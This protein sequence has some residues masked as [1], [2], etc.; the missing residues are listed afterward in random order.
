MSHELHTFISAL[1]PQS[2][3]V[4]LTEVTV[5]QAYVLLHLTA[6]A[7]TA[8]CPRCA[9]PSSSVHSRYQRQLADLPWGSLAVRIRLTVRKF[10]CRH[11]SCPRRIFTERL[12]D[13]TAPYAR[14]TTRLAAVLR[15]IGIALGGKAGARLAARLGLP[16]SATTLLRLVRGSPRPQVPTLQ[17]V[18]VDEWAWR[19]G[20][21]FGTIVVDLASHRVVE[22]LP[23][24]SAEMVG[25]W[26][27]QHPSIR[28]VCRD[29]SPLYADAIR[30]GAPEAVQVVD[31]VHLV[32]NLREAA[33]AYVRNQRAALQAAATRT[34]Q[35]LT[36]PGSLVPTTPMYQGR[37]Q[38]SQ[39]QP[40][41][42]E[43]ERQRR[44]APW[45]TI[46]ETLYTLHAQG[47]S[48][49]TI[50]RQLG[51]SRPTV[52]AYLRRTAP[53]GPKRPQF[54]RSARVLTPYVPY[55]IR[56]WRES[57]ADSAQLWR[58]IRMLGAVHSARTVCRFIT[59]LQRA[60][61]AGLA[62]EAQASPYTRPQGPSPRAVSFTLVCPAATRAPDAQIYVEQL[63]Q[64]E[65]GIAQAHALI[66]AFLAMVRERRG[67]E[68][69]AWM[70]EAT[71]SG[72]AE[73]A[74]FARGLQ[75]DLVAITAGLTLEW[76]NGVTEGHI[77]R[78]KLVKR[79]GYGRAGFALLRQRVLQAA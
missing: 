24:R 79:Q 61:E 41:W 46:Y 17:A 37:R 67:D 47:T 36:P 2:C 39:T 33:E 60:S 11:P 74:R 4:R 6:M 9:M 38:H 52:Y 25:A 40:G 71:H 14:S 12:P 7:P 28:V 20:R 53:P 5:A 58:E 1:L 73:L 59:S 72:I 13:L 69:E 70:A 43:A 66:Q 18:G 44:H 48:V 23:E 26:L 77:H 62:P 30:R 3:A 35:V 32:D 34:A 16:T 76:S 50:A 22:L 75:D 49:T 65:A 56:R 51:I 63:C 29:R 55:L 64:V 10:V 54:Q 78:L 15:A 8:A 31:R 19:R 68:L 42:Q 21:R 57:G 45:V 27:A